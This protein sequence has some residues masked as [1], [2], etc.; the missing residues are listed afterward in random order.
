MRGL[1]M[2]EQ[3]IKA[4]VI[5]VVQNDPFLSIDEIA[6]K[7]RTTPRYVRTIL[8]EA[9]LSLMQLRK[10]YA[11]HMEHQLYRKKKRVPVE[12]ADPQIRLITIQDRDIAE[13]LGQDPETN[14][15]RLSKLQLLHNFPCFCQLTT[16][17]EIEVG[18]G[19]FNGPLRQVLAAARTVEQIQLKQSWVEVV[20]NQPN[21]SRLLVHREEQPL[22]KLTYLLADQGV[23]IAVETLW[24]PTEGI[25]L[26]NQ[27]GAIEIAGESGN[28]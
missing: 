16:Y 9:N 22:L 27:G 24:L 6:A 7:V 12:K 4:K 18:A 11:K 20:S 26:C 13:L 8:S 3:T 19:N 25:L 15:L 2:V 17:L 14:L 28:V 1:M 5:Q 23:P 21:L 10:Q